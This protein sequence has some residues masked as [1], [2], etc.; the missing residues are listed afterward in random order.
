MTQISS[1][2]ASS[3]ASFSASSS[4]S[5]APSSA[6][7]SAPS[8]A[9][10]SAASTS[11]PLQRPALPLGS[12]LPWRTLLLNIVAPLVVYHLATGYGF[13]Q[14]HA[15]LLAA[16]FPFA[17]LVL[18]AIRSRSLDPIGAISLVAIVVSAGATL[19]FNDPRILLAKDSLVTATIGLAFLGSLLAPRPLIFV[20]GRRL[21]TSD[22]ERLA[23]FD[24]LWAQPRAR[25]NVRRTTVVWGAGLLAEALARAVCAVLLPA[26]VVLAISPVLS[27]GTLGLLGLWT[28]R[29][30]RGRF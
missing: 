25:A 1:A 21:A 28:F 14:T 6:V 27:L 18:G 16:I 30:Y 15:L 23:H 11:T 4:V 8:S 24:D 3:A 29:R 12:F 17:T 26:S 10:S 19:A 22:P 7:S 2:A 5:S 13:D 20:V 9:A